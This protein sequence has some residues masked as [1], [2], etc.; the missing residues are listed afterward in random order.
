MSSKATFDSTT[1]TS[2]SNF[3][4]S[5]IRNNFQSLSQGDSEPLRPRAQT[6]PDMTVLVGGALTESYYDR[7]YVEENPATYAGGNSPTVT[8]PSVNPRIDVLVASG[9]AA[10]ALH[11]L[12]GAEAA[13]PSTPTI[14]SQDIIPVC[15]VYCKTGMD[16]ILDYEDKDTDA[17]EGYIYR[18]LRPR[19]ISPQSLDKRIE[20]VDDNVD[21]VDAKVDTEIAKVVELVTGTYV[22][23]GNDDRTIT[24]GFSDTSRT[25]KLVI[26]RSKE[27]ATNRKIQFRCDEDDADHSWWSWEHTYNEG[28]NHIQSF[29]ANGFVI[30]TD[31]EVNLNTTTFMFMAWG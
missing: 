13:S 26:I 22:G 19:I 18:D 3:S 27:A 8:A 5:D 6:T 12:I 7:V 23:D 21:T 17:T 1:P 11:W 24:I 15:S 20:T 28:T 4:S 2:G 29:A 10:L 14:P 25:P 16:R 30:G 31:A 9:T